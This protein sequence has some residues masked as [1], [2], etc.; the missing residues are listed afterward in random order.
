MHTIIMADV[1]RTGGS[2]KRKNVQVA[3]RVRLVKV[4]SFEFLPVISDVVFLTTSK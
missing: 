4:L 1:K 2:G 3:V